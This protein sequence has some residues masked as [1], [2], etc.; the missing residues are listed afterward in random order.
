M[1]F[2]EDAAFAR[3]L[4]MGV[5]ATDAVRRD[6]RD[7]HGHRVIELERF[8]MANKLWQTKAK[9]LRL[10]DLLCV[11]CGR[12]IESKG[13]SQLGVILSH[14]E[15]ADR[16]WDAGGMRDDDMFAFVR[17]QVEGGDPHTSAPSYFRTADLR[18][19]RAHASESNRKATSEGSEVTLTW[20]TWVPAKSGVV[21]EV[22]DDNRILCQWSSGGSYRYYQ[23]KTWPVRHL[24]V[25][26]G[27]PVVAYE[28]MVAGIVAPT[29]PPTCPGEVWDIAEAI[30]TGDQ[31]DRYAAI[32]AA[33][34][35]GCE[36]V[37]DL[38]G[39]VHGD[40]NQDWRVRLEA[41]ASLARIDPAA[42]TGA[43]VA[44][45]MND[46]ALPE[47]R[48]ESAFVLAE[49]PTDEAAHGLAAVA[50]PGGNRSAELRAAA[51]WGLA[52][53]VRPRADLVLPFTVDADDLVSLHGI[54][55]LQSLPDELVP[56][57]RGWLAELD[58]RRAAVAAQLLMRHLHIRP[59]LEAS[60]SDGRERL[61]ALRAL[62]DLPPE[63]VENL[64]GELL[65]PEVEAALQPLWIAQRD[66]LRDGVGAEGLE[67]LDVQGLRFDPLL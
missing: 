18:D 25:P 8:A 12:R 19:V 41:A 17:V 45:A 54:T 10:P 11:A 28:T 35:L 9:A 62:G 2:K 32:R 33:G 14:S 58:D 4:S 1:G 34:I 63:L 23:W 15:A 53:G 65:T 51:V 5:V 16:G 61:W 55:G 48:M 46:E 40:E 3:F 49:I 52:R 43:V 27:S 44:V 22:D 37:V 21:A 13:K 42:W 6:L 30:A 67:A 7:V 29:A 59:L 39:Q 24:Y 26:V 31:A 47:Q 36:D 38:L 56:T 60:S 20:K 66:W 50:E 64:G 57:L